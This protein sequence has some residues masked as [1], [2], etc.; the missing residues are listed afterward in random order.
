MD[1]PHR[2]HLLDLSI[3]ILLLYFRLDVKPYRTALQAALKIV[4]DGNLASGVLA[5]KGLNLLNELLA[6]VRC[7]SGIGALTDFSVDDCVAHTNH[8]EVLRFEVNAVLLA[9]EF[10]QLRELITRLAELDE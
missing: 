1:L 5:P 4:N 8:I 3:A 10:L 9:D 2:W 6:A 7:V